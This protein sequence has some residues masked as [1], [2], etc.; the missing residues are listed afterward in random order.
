MDGVKQRSF[1][2]SVNLSADRV[3]DIFTGAGIPDTDRI[4]LSA[5]VKGLI[6]EAALAG[7]KE[8]L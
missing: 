3:P 7:D 8:V 1:Y 4:S 6:E 5:D 2:I